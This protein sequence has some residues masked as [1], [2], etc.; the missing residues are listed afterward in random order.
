MRL[1]SAESFS[2]A[3]IKDTIERKILA[4]YL[5]GVYIRIKIVQ[6]KYK[7]YSITHMKNRTKYYY[8][9]IGLS[10]MMNDEI[11][12]ECFRLSISKQEFIR[13][14]IKDYF[15]RIHGRDIVFEQKIENEY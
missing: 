14:L 10:K 15:L 1:L 11:R 9:N 6:I 12:K 2:I 13:S 7:S 5:I 8:F 3:Y 4:K